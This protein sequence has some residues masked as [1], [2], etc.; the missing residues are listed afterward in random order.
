M[1]LPVEEF[2]RRFLL[3]LL[4]RGF[5]HIRN[6]GFLAN[7]RRA[8]LLPLCFRLLQPVRSAGSMCRFADHAPRSLN[9]EL[10]ALRRTMQVVERLSAAQL[11]RRPPPHLTRCAA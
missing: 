1:T 3:H 5:M 2:L 9:M 11:L 10:S 8:E 6:F 4:P 7:R